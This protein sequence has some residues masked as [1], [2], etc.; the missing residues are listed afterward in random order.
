MA[1]S[2]LE[3]I[4][5]LFD[6]QQKL[7]PI[8]TSIKTNFSAGSNIKCVLFD[9]Y[10]TL[11]IS[12]SGDIDKLELS[13]SFILESFSQCGIEIISAN[14]NKIAGEILEEYKQT[15]AELKYSARNKNIE[16]PEIDIRDVWEIIIQSLYYRSLI[17]KPWV[18]EVKL[19]SI[20]FETLS[21]K[22]YPM[23]FMKDT[24]LQLY[25]QKIPMGIISNAQFYTP[26][27]MNYFIENEVDDENENVKYFDPDLSVYSYQE[28]IGKPNVALYEKALK[29]CQEK[30]NL[31][32]NEILFIGNDM[33]KDIYPAQTVGMRTA[34]FAGDSRS[35]RLREDDT[36]CSGISPDYI[37]DSLE[38][39]K[40]II[41]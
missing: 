38:Q 8:A 25:E 23:P 26:V 34:L 6:A 30:Y 7:Q 5:H 3:S 41:S 36:R 40:E 4:R 10:G 17:N 35:L 39:V 1:K 18:D 19:L 21:N 37:I 22:V 28:K 27:I 9:I 29:A 33:L 12:S 11:L 2:Y 13:P 20:Y 15:I 32:S 16:N 31:Q 24:I 14:P